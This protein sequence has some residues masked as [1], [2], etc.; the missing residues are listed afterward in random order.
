MFCAFL[1]SILHPAGPMDCAPP[2]G[3]EGI[4]GI[5]GIYGMNGIYQ[6]TIQ[7]FVHSSDE[8]PG[9]VPFPQAPRPGAEKNSQ[10]PTRAVLII[11]LPPDADIYFNKI[12]F[13]SASNRRTFITEDLLPDHAFFYD[14]KV[15]VMREY[16][17]YVQFQRVIFRPGET[18]TVT[19]EDIGT[20]TPFEPGW[21]YSGGSGFL[22]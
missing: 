10:F 4:N 13:R 16:R 19:F 7:P 3:P 20:R 6:L 5:N 11:R 8:L 21:R 14:V 9:E 12:Y 1:M 22:P 15:R 17:P 2:P 18:V